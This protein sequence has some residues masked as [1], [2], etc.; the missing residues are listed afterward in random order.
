MVHVDALSRIIALVS[1][2]PLERELE[3]RQLRDPVIKEIATSL[4]QVSNKKFELIEGLVFRKGPDKPLFY[5]PESMVPN[6]IR[7]YHDNCAHCGPEK[8][9]KGISTTYW[10]PSVRKRVHNYIDNCVICLLANSA[11][12]S[13]EGEMQI[14][15]RA[16]GP[17]QTI[18]MDHYGP[19]DLTEK[20]N[21]YIFL[22]IDSFSRYT[23]F[24]PVKTAATKEVLLHLKYLFNIFGNPKRIISDRGKAFAS[25]EFET[26]CK[27]RDIG[28]VL[29]GVAA[30]WANGLIERVNRFMSSSLRKLTDELQ[31][32]DDC[33]ETVQYVINNTYHTSL[34]ATPAKI[35]L[36][37]E[38]RNHPDIKLVD[39]L[40]GI[41][42]TELNYD[43]VRLSSQEIASQVNDK[44]KNYNKV[45]YDKRH[46]TPSQYKE[47]DYVLIRNVTTPGTSA[48]L[49][50]KYKGP[51]MIVK[52]LSKNRYVV[53]DIPG[54]NI[55]Q[56]PY[57][58]IL[59]PDRIK[60]WV[61]PPS[62][63][64]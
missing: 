10:F 49:Q 41:A 14:T 20:K 42:K 31:E 15:E 63:T 44:I 34:K 17:F 54:F 2:L 57:N 26:F 33:M 30:P 4:Q 55:T 46:L 16:S 3:F 18:H 19:I 5:V 6:L 62:K 32:W 39:C 12:N 25:Q 29:V 64:D 45:Y 60:P 9:I 47:G 50:A 7:V 8:T 40:N 24:F 28:H 61:K 56:R 11:S 27:D 53:A 37:Y 1:S 38:L 52:A 35:L 21:R 51:Y 36:G 23:W 58:S 22:I 48:K 43:E 13:R 59:S